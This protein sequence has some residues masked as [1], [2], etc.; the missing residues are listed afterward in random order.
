MTSGTWWAAPSRRRAGVALT[1]LVVLAVAGCGDDPGAV[2]R[3]SAVSALEGSLSEART[4][5]L[6]GRL[7]VRDRSTHAFA[8]VVVGESDTGVGADAAW[9]EEQQPPR[10]AD[11]AVRQRT[12]EA[13]DGAASAVQSVRIALERSDTV[14]THAAL[15]GLRAACADLEALAGELS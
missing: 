4:A 10:R 5:E 13:L 14:A 8:V 9:F 2:Y 7:W 3:D 1:L 11:D 6:A 15:D 12:T